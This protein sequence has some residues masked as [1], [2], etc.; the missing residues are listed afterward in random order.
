[1]SSRKKITIGPLPEQRED[2]SHYEE[3][4]IRWD[5]I[6]V[7]GI[8]VLLL[9]GGL[10]N[11]FATDGDSAVEVSD[12]SKTEQKVKVPS[13]VQV[14]P[15]QTNDTQKTAEETKVLVSDNRVIATDNKATVIDNNVVVA[16]KK[17]APKV[18]ENA[19][20]SH[21]S[22]QDKPS[23]AKVT[24]AKPPAVSTKAPEQPVLEPKA[25]DKDLS[26]SSI[27]ITNSAIKEAILR[28][29]TEKGLPGALVSH[30]IIMPSKGLV[31]VMLQTEMYGLKGTTL[32]HDWYRDGK[33]QARV[34]I[35]VNVA[36]QRS[37]SS[38]FIDKYMLGS[39]QVKVVDAAG[40]PYILA[41]FDVI[42]GD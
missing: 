24:E 34:K 29:S 5:R 28:L 6:I 41:D 31:K 21:Q 36:Q 14:L 4:E 11:L 23:V 13:A 3:S 18:Q 10:V 33:R 9:I 30:D 12:N 40:E 25:R 17:T 15:E 32:Y 38:K 8:V 39:W 19:A 37:Y 42:S 7:V 16:D 27:L 20:P 22:T 26:P 1:M 2:Y 35:P